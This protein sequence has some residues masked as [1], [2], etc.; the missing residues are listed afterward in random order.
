MRSKWLLLIVLLMLEGTG[1]SQI[2][3]NVYERVLYIRIPGGTASAFTIEVDGRQYI[4]TAKHAVASLPEESTIEYDRAN[5]WVR[6]PV[7]IY[8][9]EDPTDIAVLVPPF[10]LTTAF[11]MPFEPGK[12]AYGQDTFFLG[13]PYG[14][15]L[16]GTNVNGTLPMPFVKKAIYSGTLPL[17]PEKHSILLLLDG[18][19]NPGFSG[20][21][22]VYK[23]PSSSSLNYNVIGVI[24]GFQPDISPIVEKH[25]IKSRDEASPEAKEQPWRINTNPD[26]TLFEYKDTDKKVPLNTGI[27]RA[28][29][30]FPAIE[31]I[32]KHPSGPIA[33]RQK[34]DFP[35]D[36]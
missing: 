7:H 15:T 1:S 18:F 5:K 28:F 29:A 27:V 14:L 22:V 4:I 16:N 30:L 35:A 21:P 8:K 36:K 23:D 25:S 17:A 32:R 26:G 11:N 20:G 31:L 33:D 13:F 12:I 24:S 10:Q 19:N 34:M 6:L 3:G 9:C 2:T